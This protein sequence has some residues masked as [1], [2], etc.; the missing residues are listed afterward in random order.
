MATQIW[1]SGGGTQ[2]A[3]IAVLI[4]SG[5]LPKPDWAVIADTGR[6]TGETW[7]YLDRIVNPALSDVGLKVE[8]LP[9]SDV[10]SVFENAT[11][12]LPVFATGHVKF[13]AFCSSHWKREVV[14]AAAAERGLLPAVNWVGI[15]TN[16]MQRVRVPRCANWQ[17]RY[18][19]VFDVPLSRSA[20]RQLVCDFGWPEPPRSSCWM[21]PNRSNSEWIHLRDNR[22]DEF[23]SAV[24]L[25]RE[26]R[27]SKPDVFFHRSLVPL[28][29]VDFSR[30][31]EQLGLFGCESGA[32]FV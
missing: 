5:R 7:D 2:S 10:P 29:E 32:C 3:A 28:G 21:C 14:K 6:E 12:L 22:P 23:L 20:C 26:V 9:C 13:R 1:S 16:E 30:P 19:L 8:R 24:A 17:L 11:L 25:E 31:D 15:S 27:A 4:L 18:P